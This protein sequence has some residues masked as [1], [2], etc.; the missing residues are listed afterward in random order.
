MAA[1]KKKLKMENIKKNSDTE[2]LSTIERI[3][4]HERE[5][6]LITATIFMV[7][8]LLA[9]F[10]IFGNYN[11]NKAFNLFKIGNLDVVYESSVTGLSDV[12]T[13]NEESVVNSNEDGLKTESHNFTIASSVKGRH[14]FNVYI[15]NDL[16]MI[17][18]DGCGDMLVN[19]DAIYY[20]INDGE[21]KRLSD[22][23]QD[24]Y[25]LILSDVIEDKKTKNF[26]IKLWIM[27]G[28]MVDPNKVH[29]HGNIIVNE[30]ED[31]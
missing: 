16:A 25:Y 13:L 21:V 30:I 9:L 23:K 17:N 26:E 7:I 14:K 31:E 19:D 3:K 24:N 12:I 27:Q 10:I 1:Q 18:I 11:R 15:Q 5:Y 4:L 2:I 22:V 8:I 6:L 20:S 29:F 28:D